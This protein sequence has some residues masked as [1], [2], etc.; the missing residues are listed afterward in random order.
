M[1][2]PSTRYFTAGEVETGAY[3]N[4]SVT[5]LGNFML[6]RPVAQLVTS[7]AGGNAVAA[8]TAVAIPFTSSNINRDNAWSSGT[9]PSRYTAATAGWYWVSGSMSWAN[10]A[11]TY[12]SS[13]LRTNGSTAVPGSTFTI[14]G[15][16][17]AGS[18]T[19][20]SNGFVYLNGTTDYI[21]LIAYSGTATTLGTPPSGTAAQT[22]CLTVV[23]VSL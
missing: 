11:L 5:N 9:N 2:V 21:E 17:T 1:I 16:S 14:L 3:L 12:R 20:T 18:Q 6:G 8:T 10:T 4:A 13:F 23:W 15:S 19:T 22:A 7:T